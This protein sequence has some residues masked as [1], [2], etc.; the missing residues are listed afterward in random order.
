MR[1]VINATG[2]I[3]HTGLGRAPLGKDIIEK[4][5]DMASGYLDLEFNLDTGERGE[6][7]EELENRI[8]RLTGFESA[9]IF[10]NNAGA[11]LALISTLARGK[12][13]LALRSELVA[14]G[15]SFRVPEVVEMSQASLFPVG[16]MDGC[17]L[18]ELRKAVDEIKPELILKT[19]TS[20]YRIETMS[21]FPL[22]KESIEIGRE[23]NIQV[24]YDIGSG[25]I[26]GDIPE[27][28]IKNLSGIGLSAVCFS[29]DKLLGGPQCGIIVADKY[30]ISRV[31]K[32]PIAR[33]VRID[34]IT[35]L[36]LG[37]TLDNYLSFK[38]YPTLSHELI[39]RNINDRKKIAEKIAV[40]F[41]EIGFKATLVESIGRLGSGA[42]PMHD[43]PSF[44][45]ALDEKDYPIEKVA[46]LFRLSDP[47]V[48][49]R[50]S[51]GLFEIDVA[52]IIDGEVESIISSAIKVKR[53]LEEKE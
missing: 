14:I 43:L 52:A 30:I 40:S 28:C 35:A 38:K 39:Y 34:K 22:L 51:K 48:I 7:Q 5:S 8:T 31:R 2:V 23:R 24:I 45:V 16:A 1:K 29:G 41:Q 46:R 47:S 53:I 27:E 32:N 4:L 6:R 13:V 19:H 42:L 33:A 18:D 20:N 3:L 17:S 12:K 10:N 36:L 50:K 44:A 49:G 25:Q 9:A 37:F 26:T 15:G 11:L 21:S